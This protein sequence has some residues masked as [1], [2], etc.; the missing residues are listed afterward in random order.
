MNRLQKVALVITAVGL[1]T[2]M[3]VGGGTNIDRS[4]P[5]VYMAYS[6]GEPVKTI[7][8]VAIKIRNTMV[9]VMLGND[10]VMKVEHRKYYGEKTTASAGPDLNGALTPIT[11]S[12]QAVKSSVQ[13]D[14]SVI[15]ITIE[16]EAGWTHCLA[17][18][19]SSPASAGLT[20]TCK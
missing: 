7:E 18:T 12:W 2:A 19:G 17:L 4:V 1:L 3:V 9:L 16:D 20:V 8:T 6:D 5:Q 11:A 14:F 15:H 10:H 13:G